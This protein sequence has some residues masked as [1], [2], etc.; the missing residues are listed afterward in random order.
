MPQAKDAEPQKYHPTSHG[1]EI[2]PRRPPVSTTAEVQWRE[3][4]LAFLQDH[5]NSIQE[6]SLVTEPVALRGARLPGKQ[7]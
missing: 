1:P 3:D 6:N 4:V 5:A 2:F 7:L